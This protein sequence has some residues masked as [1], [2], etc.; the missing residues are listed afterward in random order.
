MSSGS[1]PEQSR[2]SVRGEGSR[3]SP[4]EYNFGDSLFSPEQI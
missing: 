2:Q 1:F 4:E 3:Q